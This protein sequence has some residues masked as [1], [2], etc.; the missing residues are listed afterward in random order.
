MLNYDR[1]NVLEGVDVNKTSSSKGCD[2]WCH[3][4]FLNYSFKSQP[5]VCNRC[6]TY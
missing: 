5:N 6:H 2:I 4:H 1:I 3:W